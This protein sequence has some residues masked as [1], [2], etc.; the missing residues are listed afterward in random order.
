MKKFF[1]K[2]TF[3]ISVILLL[4]FLSITWFRGQYL[5]NPGDT[6]FSFNP[7]L[8][9]YRSLFTWDH[10]QELGRLDSM[11]AAKI[12]PYNF[13]LSLLSFLGVSIYASQKILFYLVFTLSGLAAYFL[14]KYLFSPNRYVKIGALLGANF[15]MMNSFLIQIRWGDGY[16]MAL[17]TYMVFPLLILFWLKGRETKN[18]KFSL[19]FNLIFL[20]ALPSFTNA[21]LIS[22]IIIICVLDGLIQIFLNFKKKK[23]L[24]SLFKFSGVF[25]LIFISTFFFWI[26]S[27]VIPLKDELFYLVK[28]T[29]LFGVVETSSTMTSVLN[30]LRGLGFWGFWGDYNG[31]LYHPHSWPYNS[32]VFIV[33][34]FLITILSLMPLFLLK[35]QNRREK[36]F[37]FFFALVLMAGICLSKGTQK[38]LGV[39]Y[40][41]A[42]KNIPV[43]NIFRFPQ[44]KFGHLMVIGNT[45]LIGYSLIFLL[46]IFKEKWKKI[47]PILFFLLLINIY[48]WPFWTGDIWKEQTIFLP[49]YRF[50]I[51]GEY[52][53]LKDFLNEEKID[54]R[55]FN[56]PDNFTSVPGI[57]SINLEKRLY[58]GSDPLSRLLSL[59]V[60]YLNNFDLAVFGPLI[61]NLYSRY[62]DDPESFSLNLRK[63]SGLFNTKYI[64]LRGESDNNL[65]RRIKSP[66]HI[67]PFLDSDFNLLKRFGSLSLYQADENY[68]LPHFYIPQKIICTSGGAESI[69]DIVSFGGNPVR[70]GIYFGNAEET[71]FPKV[72]DIFIKMELEDEIMDE[73]L[74]ME[75]RPEEVVFPYARQRPGSLIYPLVLKKEMVEKWKV[76]KDPE[77]LFGGYLFFAGK[78]ITEFINFVDKIDGQSA[79]QTIELYRQEMMAASKILGDLK[80]EGSKDF[81]KLWVKYRATLLA[82]RERIEGMTKSSD[83]EIV[84]TDLENELYRLKIERDFSKLTYEFK[85]P[86]AGEYLVYQK[87]QDDKWNNIET[88]EFT[89]GEHKLS[90]PSRG[91]SG[92]LLEINLKIKDYSPISIFR[93]SFDYKTQSASAGFSIIENA[94]QDKAEEKILLVKR[95]LLKSKGGEFEN[96][97]M[98]FKSSPEATNAAIFLSTLEEEGV[99]VEFRNIQVQRFLPLLLRSTKFQTADLKPKIP[100]ITFIKVNPTK[101]RILVEGAKEPYSLVFSEGFHKGWK[102]YVSDQRSVNSDRYGEV[103]ASYFDGEIKEGTHQNI[104]LDKNIFE[105]WRKKPISEERHS[106]VNGYANSWYITPEDSGGR[107]NYEL[108]VEFEPQRFSYLGFFVSMLSLVGSF[109][110]LIIVFFK[111]KWT[112]N[113]R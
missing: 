83:W 41:L 37:L 68:F 62:I 102:A 110:Y 80:L 38:P 9:F 8:D 92:N 88:R 65:Y 70:S 93:L 50:R 33:I 19:F 31:D 99:E 60:F 17:F 26:V 51:P 67:K 54:T 27:H 98:F 7:P 28:S 55:I 87:N 57:I 4:G 107:E 105:T 89:K 112:R 46:Q 108:I 100:Q 104:F 58:V 16:Y 106:L 84:F 74:G 36:F 79:N 10:Q 3:Y 81:V 35:K 6:N 111:K 109:C 23:E 11:A 63:L 82:H 44:D 43:F 15:Y 45:V 113:S 22:P 59:P 30:L 72:D 77:K 52:Y 24:I 94:D 76:R 29:P 5:V 13:L 101:Y 14:I 49:G 73:K 75:T 97:E 12:F 34:G 39:I 71:I 103:V 53:Q 2:D 66:D 95:R 56:L 91:I 21:A 48:A 86:M 47:L 42:L 20:L 64:L 1:Q 40:D 32:P 85:I 61:N 96:F 90:L 69:A 78:R 18:I 25:L